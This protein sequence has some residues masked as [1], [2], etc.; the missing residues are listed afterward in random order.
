[1]SDPIISPVVSKIVTP[2]VE[3]IVPSSGDVNLFEDPS[4]GPWIGGVGWVDNGDGTWTC[5]TPGSNSD[6][7]KNINALMTEGNNYEIGFHV[8]TGSGQHNMKVAGTISAA[9]AYPGPDTLSIQTMIMALGSTSTG[10]RC[11]STSTYTIDVTK[12][13]VY[14]RGTASAGAHL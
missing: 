7:Y 6:L 9:L 12:S 8:V 14:D 3:P 2:V 4:A 11:R 5:T 10:F 13:Y 1:M